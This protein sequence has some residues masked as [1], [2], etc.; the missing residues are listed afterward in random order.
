M[1]VEKD[2]LTRHVDALLDDLLPGLP[3]FFLTG[4]RGCGKSTTAG[5]RCASTIHL[6]SLPE[7]TAFELDPDL[8][9]AQQPSPVLLDEWQESPQCLG[10]VKRA[11]DTRAPNRRYLIT[12]STRARLGG[13]TWPLTG[14]AIPVPM[15]P[16]TVAE[17]NGRPQAGPAWLNRVF[18]A[19][20]PATAKLPD[21]PGLGT[22]LEMA[23]RGGMPG[24]LSMNPRQR[25][26]WLSG[27]QAQLTERDV[28]E[29][30]PVRNPAGLGRLLQAV[31]LNTAG[32][33]HLKTLQE[34]AHVD[35]K[36]SNNYLDLLEDLRVVER[37]PA[38]SI[39]QLSRLVKTPKYY[40]TDT[41]L[42]AHAAAW[43]VAELLKNGDALG[44]LLDTLVLCQL[45]PLL[46]LASPA[47]RVFHLRDGNGEHEI[48]L[49]L[50]DPAGRLV[51]IEVKAAAAAT[52]R[53]ARHLAW[54]RD[55]FPDRFHRGIVFNTGPMTYPIETGIWA[56]PIATL[57]HPEASPMP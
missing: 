55:K 6:D 35:A 33:P 26:A 54:L 52:R 48:D 31:A 53:D 28:A 20:D 9:L 32:L 44:R 41:G 22:Y 23:T 16:L 10:A 2:Y 36:T 1:A 47:P 12:G 25:A 50:E 42:A 56:M 37:V 7:R 3:A 43:G 38:W 17:L 45:R 30:A 21:A 24:T 57:W 51:A 5:R 29:L 49:I 39:N 19:A 4:P 15:W 11:V 40:L 18:G 14:R 13:Q 8:V 34:A 27:Y 46:A